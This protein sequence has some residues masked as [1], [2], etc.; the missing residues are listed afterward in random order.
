[1]LTQS[2]IHSKFNCSPLQGHEARNAIIQLKSSVHQMSNK[3]EWLVRAAKKVDGAS[4]LISIGFEYVTQVEGFKM[5]R[6]H[7]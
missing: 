2:K 7:K 4:E 3:G 1:M 6:K 5:F